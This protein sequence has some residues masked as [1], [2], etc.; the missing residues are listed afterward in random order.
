MTYRETMKDLLIRYLSGSWS[1]E[2][3]LQQLERAKDAA[4]V[5]AVLEER[6]ACAK[7]A[8][9]YFDSGEIVD[10]IRARST[11]SSAPQEG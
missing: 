10:E 8:A 3:V 1:S 4:V 11:A 2:Y 5:A 9:K 7:I 6:E